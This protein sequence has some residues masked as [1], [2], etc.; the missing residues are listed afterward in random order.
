MPLIVQSSL[1]YCKV[2]HTCSEEVR[3]PPPMKFFSPPRHQN[4]PL[5]S[6]NYRKLFTNKTE[7]RFSPYPRKSKKRRPHLDVERGFR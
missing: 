7:N 1:V 3:V 6:L 2:Y 5:T 4:R